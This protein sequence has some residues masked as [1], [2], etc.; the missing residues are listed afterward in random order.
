MCLH[1]A[2][3]NRQPVV[4]GRVMSLAGRFATEPQVAPKG[5]RFHLIHGEQDNVIAADCSIQAGR[6]LRQLGASASID[7]LP[8]LGHTIDSRVV[9]I[10]QGRR[11]ESKI[12]DYADAG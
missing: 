10:I 9:H 1:A 11:S 2:L 5:V 3:A 6:R 12:P 7:L 4:A 8:G